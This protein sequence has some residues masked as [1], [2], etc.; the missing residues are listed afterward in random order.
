MKNNISL[1]K[2]KHHSFS[3]LYKILL[4]SYVKLFK[5]DELNEDDRKT[6]LSLI[7]LFMNQSDRMMQRLAYR[8]ALAY[9]NKTKD[10]LPLHD[11]ALNWGLIPVAALIRK[12]KSSDLNADRFLS[13]IVET[14]IEKFRDREILETE[15]QVR[16]KRFFLENSN[17]SVT[18]IAPTSYGKSELIT[19][20]IKLSKGKRICIVVPSK[21]LLAQTKKRL[22]EEKI[23]WVSK[24]IVHPDMYRKSDMSAVY[25][26]T[27]ERLGAILNENRDAYFDIVFIDEAH[28]LLEKEHRNIL[29]ASVLNI[30][31]HRNKNVAFKFLTPFLHEPENL[32]LK[33]ANGSKAN[34]KVG[35]YVKSEHLYFVDYRI[36]LPKKYIYDQFFDES[37][38]VSEVGSNY[39]NYIFENS[40]SKNVIY[41]NRPK[42]IQILAQQI[43]GELP[44]INFSKMDVAFHEIA[45]ATHEDYLLLKCLKRGVLYHH[46]SMTESIRNFV[47]Y[48][49]RSSPEIRYLVTSSTLLE[50]VNL[51]VEKMFV[52][53]LSK[54]RRTMTAAQFKNLIGRVSRFKD[55]FSSF[56]F[57][58]ISR[59][60]PEVHIVAT[61]LYVRK[62]AKLEDFCSRVLWV[63]KKDK[64]II[65]NVLLENSVLT[66]GGQ[67]LYDQTM[68]RLCNVEPGIF[69]EY[70]YIKCATSIGESL[71]KNSISEINVIEHESTIAKKLEESLN[72]GLINSTNLLMRI[73]FECFIKFVDRE[74]KS[75]A[76]ALVRLESD[77]AQ[78]FYAMFLDWASE[79]APMSLMIARFLGY[80]NRLPKETPIFV[81]SWGDQVKEGGYQELYTFIDNKSDAEKVNLAIVRI[82]E[83]EDFLQYNLLRYVEVLNDVGAL[84][85]DFYKLAKYGT[86]DDRI[87]ALMRNGYS[88]SVSDLLLKKYLKF[89]KFLENDVVEI[90][91]SVAKLMERDKIGFLQRSELKLNSNIGFSEAE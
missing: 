37:F 43:A 14:Y 68:T 76:R 75:A 31:H 8:M 58:S 85:E 41:L 77:K 32:S 36:E 29:L 24:V 22:L 86:K 65:E 70:P 11:L 78:T 17:Q 62:N 38:V 63:E 45:D 73:I 46:G 33:H 59:L 23:D 25:V 71:L 69:P 40:A 57:N 39:L 81:G 47:E 60:Q 9:G 48:L 34:F 10:L 28:N 88:R 2:I 26:L 55:V 18:V 52:L 1:G 66:E 15:A 12:I 87:I 79:N 49:Y 51:P 6:I 67:A 42:H 74:N 50:G 21:A 84:D 90:D 27:Q 80:W 61:T 4:T 30:L 16:L 72:G 83:E 64:D 5:A 56:E 19:T 82:K 44:E 53:S 54:G 20:L 89:L 91:P 7:V 13:E 35:E 3:E